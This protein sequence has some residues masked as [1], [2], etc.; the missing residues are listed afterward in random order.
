M[1]LA[2][3]RR[4]ADKCGWRIKGLYG[5]MFGPELV[6]AQISR[7]KP[8]G[9]VIGSGEDERAVRVL[10]LVARSLAHIV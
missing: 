5:R 8:A 7:L 4:Y 1:K 3:I 9:V 2:G 10:A 6:T